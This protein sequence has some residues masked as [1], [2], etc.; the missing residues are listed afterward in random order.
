M[1]NE[2]S[3]REV[4]LCASV[5]L[6]RAFFFAISAAVCALAASPAFAKDPEIRQDRADAKAESAYYKIIEIP[7]PEDI[8][9]ECGGFENMP[10][11][12]V[13]VS[14]RRG[15]IYRVEGALKDPPTD[16]KFTRWATGLHEV[17]G[18]AYNP[19]DGF[20]YACQRG[21]ITKLKDTDKDGV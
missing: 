13:M 2:N 1:W 11:G 19:K 20:L 8:V 21:E 7:I 3:Q 10:D 15:D 5:S 14:T 6:W 12:S 17:L 9:L 18:L 16:V 4:G